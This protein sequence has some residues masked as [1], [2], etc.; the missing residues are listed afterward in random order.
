MVI[1][2]MYAASLDYYR[3]GLAELNYHRRSMVK[4]GHVD[5][6][7][8]APGQLLGVGIAHALV[9]S[10]LILIIPKA[11]QEEQSVPLRH[12]Q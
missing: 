8:P 10:Y 12:G 5:P 7:V 2:E 6:V 11:C 3:L 9:E 4:V 1:L